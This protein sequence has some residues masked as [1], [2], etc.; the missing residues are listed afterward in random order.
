MI[1]LKTFK[2]GS[3]LDKIY[4]ILKSFLDEQIEI[5]PLK[6]SFIINQTESVKDPT[7]TQ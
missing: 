3:V 4:L 7:S 6:N 1:F 2:E 5:I